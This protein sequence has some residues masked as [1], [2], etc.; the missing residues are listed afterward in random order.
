MEDKT[1]F[2]PYGVASGVNSVVVAGA[3]TTGVGDNVFP[4]YGPSMRVFKCDDEYY[5][6]RYTNNVNNHYQLATNVSSGSRYDLSTVDTISWLKSHN[7]MS[8]DV[9]FNSSWTS[10]YFAYKLDLIAST[11]SSTGG[12]SEYG[13]FYIDSLNPIYSD[14]PILN[15]CSSLTVLSTESSVNNTRFIP[16]FSYSVSSGSDDSGSGGSTDISPLIP[17]I[18]MIPATIIVV[19]F[20]SVIYKMFMNRKVR[21]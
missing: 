15:S 9:Y 1:V 19:C 21:G 10:Y 17:A 3:D 2:L 20:F 12:S 4:A 7:L 14:Q 6:T 5:L 8:E 18:L 16:K 11:L 13:Y